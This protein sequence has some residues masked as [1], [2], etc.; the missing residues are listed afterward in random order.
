M[1]ALSP[2][3]STLLDVPRAHVD[4]ICSLIEAL[5]V[6]ALATERPLQHSTTALLLD[7]RRCGVGLVRTRASHCDATHFIIGEASRVENVHAVFIATTR[8]QQTVQF[9]DGDDYLSMVHLLSHAGIS[10][11]EWVV[12]GRGGLYC[13]RALTD[14]PSQWPTP[15]YLR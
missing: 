15:P 2:F 11:T 10:L 1:F 14:L 3:E 6:V 7:A 13:P 8:P 4:P 5:S 9:A 12:L